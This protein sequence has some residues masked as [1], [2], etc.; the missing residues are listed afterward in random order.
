VPWF[1]SGLVSLWALG[2]RVLVGRFYTGQDQ[3]RTDIADL[4]TDVAIIKGVLKE[5]DRNGTHSWPGDLQ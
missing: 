1:I 5:R 4:K 2:L 3:I